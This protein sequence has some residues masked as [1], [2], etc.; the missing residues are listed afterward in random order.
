MSEPDDEATVV[1]ATSPARL[2]ITVRGEVHTV[3]PTDAP[4]TIGRALPAQIRIDDQRISRSHLR[5]EHAN[6]RWRAVD[7][8]TNGVFLNGERQSTVTL[9]GP[10]TLHLGNPEGIAVDLGPAP[11]DEPHGSGSPTAVADGTDDS[12][13]EHTEEYDVTDVGIARA[14]AAV[15]ARRRELDIA[16]RALAKDRVMNA[17]ALI[18]FEKGRSWPR[19]STR[20]RLESVLGWAPGTIASI[21]HGESGS[22]VEVEERTEAHSGSVDAPLM[23]EAVNVALDAMR[24][25]IDSLPSPSDP[26]FTESADG[27]LG[28]LR[29]LEGVAARTARA[30]RGAPEVAL[31]LSAVRRLHRE[32][33]LR[34]ASAPGATFG[35]RLFAARHRAELSAEEAA[36]AAGV[37][38]EA[39]IAAEADAALDAGD[40]AA[41]QALLSSLSK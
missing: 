25:R 15:A 13:D 16:Q 14:G 38:V 7:T 3:E 36:N 11:P 19:Q 31:S 6:G 35:Q 4:I 41:L 27:I 29:R 20:A 34:A 23:A 24:A 8:S 5:L 18:A 39:V 32:L 17:G 40:S 2:T 22:P 21:R 10:T 37:A 33:M 30:A 26:T 12:F 1:A 28:D 9:A